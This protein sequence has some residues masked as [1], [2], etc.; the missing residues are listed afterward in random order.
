MLCLLHHPSLDPN[1]WCGLSNALSINGS[2]RSV[3]CLQCHLLRGILGVS[4]LENFSFEKYWKNHKPCSTNN[5]EE[6][7]LTYHCSFI[8]QW[9]LAWCVLHLF[10][11]PSVCSFCN[12]IYHSRPSAFQ[13]NYLFIN[14]HYHHTIY[15]LYINYIFFKIYSSHLLDFSIKH[16]YI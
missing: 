5:V 9:I 2:L 12:V 4:R 1:P 3:L 14:I 8:R 6:M 15:L 7:Q 10:R 13:Q 16:F 11:H